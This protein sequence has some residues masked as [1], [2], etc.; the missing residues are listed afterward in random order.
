MAFEHPISSQIGTTKDTGTRRKKERLYLMDNHKYVVKCFRNGKK[1]IKIQMTESLFPDACHD[2]IA[3]LNHLEHLDAP[4][5]FFEWKP[6][7][8]HTHVFFFLIF[9][10][11]TSFEVAKR[12]ELVA[13]DD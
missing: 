8:I 5:H 6:N 12:T 7:D 11:P 9:Y 13:P 10:N 1:R 3:M 4:I 2:A